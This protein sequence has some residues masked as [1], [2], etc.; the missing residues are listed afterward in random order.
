LVRCY[1]SDVDITI[2]TIAN[3]TIGIANDKTSDADAY[4]SLSV[5]VL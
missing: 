4:I 5:I 2:Q 3:I 1:Y